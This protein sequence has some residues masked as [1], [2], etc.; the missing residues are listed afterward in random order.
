MRGDKAK[1]KSFAAPS[2]ALITSHGAEADAAL[3]KAIRSCLDPNPANRPSAGDVHKVLLAWSQ[4]KVLRGTTP[5]PPPPGSDLK[6]TSVDTGRSLDP[7]VLKT[8]FGSRLAALF[9]SADD[10]KFFGSRLFTLMP[11]DGAWHVVPD[12]SAVNATLLNG[13]QIAGKTALHEGD[14]LAV[15]SRKNSSVVKSR[16]KVSFC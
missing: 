9:V 7:L 5:P 10:A 12:E 11:E 8:D 16:I 14:E 6:L 1:V 2:P 3:Q 4:G 13:R 15:G